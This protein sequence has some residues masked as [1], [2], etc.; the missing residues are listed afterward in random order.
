MKTSPKFSEYPPNRPI[1]QKRLENALVLIAKILLLILLGVNVLLC[2]PILLLGFLLRR[3]N[4][5]ISNKIATI[6]SYTTW[7]ILNWFFRLSAQMEVPDIPKG[8]YLVISNHISAVDFAL[9]NSINMHMFPHSK[10]AFKKSLRYVPFFY[11]GFLALNYL[12]LERNFEKDQKNIDEYIK[13]LRIEQ[14]PL[15][16][17]WF[18]EGGRF[19][20]EKKILSDE[21]CMKEGIEPFENVLMPRNKGFSRIKEGLEHSYVRK[22]LDLT[23]YC[24]RDDFSTMGLL[25]GTQKY[26]FRCDARLIDIPDIDQPKEF[27]IEV[28]RRKD[29]LIN[30]WKK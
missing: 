28:F 21:F 20:K 7:T 30:S 3:V 17:V 14:Y 19:S 15:W 22:V 27:L 11:Q 16:L 26:K 6:T 13:E 10:Y 25:F 18:C 5:R 2:L 23:F 4:K 12:L 24:D 9:I 8:N 1:W 29:E